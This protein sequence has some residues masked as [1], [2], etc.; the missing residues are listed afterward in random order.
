MTQVRLTGHIVVPEADLADVKAELPIHIRLTLEEH[1]CLS[2]SV[3]PCAENPL[4]FDV[5]EVFTDKAAFE[6]HQRR[7]KASRWGGITVNVERHYEI[8]YD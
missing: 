8:S 5:H 4:R 3:T 2:F 6:A 7:V 1:G